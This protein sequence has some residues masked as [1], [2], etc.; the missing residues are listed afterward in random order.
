MKKRQSKTKTPLIRAA[1]SKPKPAEDLPRRRRRRRR[2]VVHRHGAV[3]RLA[4]LEERLLR[5]LV[6]RQEPR[7]HFLDLGLDRIG[8]AVAEVIVLE[9]RM[10]HFDA[11]IR[12]YVL[13]RD[14][15]SIGLEVVGAERQDP[16][17]AGHQD[18]HADVSSVTTLLT[19]SGC[20]P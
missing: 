7:K 11:D 17:P 20:W 6:F 10:H 5:W 9:F 2:R 15:A 8:A 19:R 4:L 14:H 16:L 13:G 3:V 1:F 12:G 18:R